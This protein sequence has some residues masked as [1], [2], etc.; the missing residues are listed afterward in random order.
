MVLFFFLLD[1]LCQLRQQPRGAVDLVSDVLAVRRWIFEATQRTAGDRADLIEVAFQRGRW[2]LPL[3][4]R[5]QKQFRRGE[6]ALAGNAFG[7]APGV[8]EVG[9][10][11]R[12]PM[13]L[14]E[15]LRHALALFRIDSRRGRQVAHGNLRGDT[16]LAYEL[17]DGFGKRFHQRQAACHP[18]RAVVETP[19]QIVD[20]VAELLFHLG[21][22]PTLFE[23]RFRLAV[24]T[25]ATNQQQRFGFAHRVQ[26][27]GVDCVAPQLLQ[28][29]DALV[30]VDHQKL[31][32]LWD[33]DDGRLL[34]GF[35][36]RPQ[37]PPES[38]RLADPEMLQAAVQL[39]KLQGLRHGVVSLGFQYARHWHWSFAAE[40]G[41]CQ[42][43]L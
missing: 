18:R 27:D 3:L 13:L 40:W 16:A 31:R 22:Q 39:M 4:P 7:V 9:G 38:R 42:Q 17:L 14:R 15:D 26:H 43:P 29:G 11:A 2:G 1:S 21:Q 36:Q 34:S 33:D 35:S 37:Q 32:G 41:C 5:F 25:Q 10:L 8:I 6:N 24:H 20:R 28:R 19:R 23:R 30:A 12:G